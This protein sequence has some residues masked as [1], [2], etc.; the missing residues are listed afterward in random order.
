MKINGLS[1]I[2]NLL[3]IAILAIALVM[4]LTSPASVG[5]APAAQATDTATVSATMAATPVATATTTAPSTLP[6]TG[7][8]DQSLA[9]G[10]MTVVGL[11]FLGMGLALRAF[12]PKNT[13]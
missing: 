12:A 4:A 10:L 7:A 5:A 9:L 6:T 11:G 8:A 3:G 2:A 1:G 13:R